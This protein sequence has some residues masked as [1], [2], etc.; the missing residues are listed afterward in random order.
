MVIDCSPITSSAATAANSAG[1]MNPGCPVAS[2]TNTTAAKRDPVAGAEERGD[3]QQDVQRRVERI[4][5][6]ADATP[7]D[8][9]ADH[10]RHE[11]PADTTAGQRRRRR[12][13]SKREHRREQPQRVFLGQPSDHL[14]AGPDREAL[15]GQQP[16]D[17]EQ[18]DQRDAGQRAHEAPL[19]GT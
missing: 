15:T 9:P 2:A 11:Q 12:E 13:A 1:T 7:D 8:R 3:A 6:V 17:H 4:D 18:H 19:A 16:A 5:D 14:V 10:Q